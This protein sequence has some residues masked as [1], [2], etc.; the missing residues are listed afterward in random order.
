VNS[1]KRKGELQV[2]T[3]KYEIVEKDTEARDNI[4]SSLV[5]KPT[6][7]VAFLFL[8]AG[9]PMSASDIVDFLS[10]SDDWYKE[11]FNVAIQELVDMGLIQ[12]TVHSE[13]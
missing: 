13:N 11:K 5:E 4:L 7:G 9:G 1:R 10:I 6:H 8:M 3:V 12:E 2:S